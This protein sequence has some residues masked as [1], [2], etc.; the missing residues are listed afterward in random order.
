MTCHAA[1]RV[2]EFEQRLWR[3]RHDVWRALVITDAEL[4]CLEPHQPGELFDEAATETTR[5]LLSRLE[6]RDR[7]V[8]TEI[9]AAECRLSSGMFGVCEACDRPIP[10][11]RLRALPTARLCVGCEEAAERAVLR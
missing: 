8:L 1:R 5:R 9:D 7:H 4:A 3:E 2:G 10:F 11:T 6:E